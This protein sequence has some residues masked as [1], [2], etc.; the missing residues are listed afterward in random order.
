MRNNVDFPWISENTA[1]KWQAN[2]VRWSNEP[3]V[4]V[5]VGRIDAF[6]FP[7][8]FIKR[9]MQQP[10]A[11]GIRA[12]FG[13]MNEQD[14]CNPEETGV[15]CGE[16]LIL[17]AINRR[18]KDIVRTENCPWD[19]DERTIC[20]NFGFPED[21]GLIL[22]TGEFCPPFCDPDGIGGGG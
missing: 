18:G 6:S 16:K 11:V 14:D 5:P 20:R 13:I 9:L 22:N 3:V 7:E 8:K 21:Q 15:A 12:Y 1:R 4:K 10:G 17:V 2:Y 19:N